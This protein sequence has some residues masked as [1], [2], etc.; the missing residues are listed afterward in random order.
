M[1]GYQH[2]SEFE[3]GFIV[4]VREMGHSISEIRQEWNP[5]RLRRI[6]KRNR[7]ATLSQIA[8]YFNAGPSTS[9]TVRTI[10]R[11]IIDMGFRSRR[12]THIPLLTA[13]HKALSLIWAR[14]H[15]HWTVD[16]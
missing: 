14:Q 5:R 15:H 1:A 13:R 9:V 12:P 11:N 2:L 6:I 3:G 8:A 4:G 16:D 10:Q 7:R